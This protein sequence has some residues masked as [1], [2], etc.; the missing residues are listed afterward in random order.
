M[1]T[2]MTGV[3]LIGHG[4]LDQLDIRND[5]PVPAPKADEVLIKVSAAGVNNTDI[6]T[7]IGWYSKGDNDS[8]MQ[9]GMAKL[10]NYHEFKARMCVVILLR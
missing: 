5:I 4:E 9:A 6:N 3:Q 1:S 8:K 7:R 10:W 2:V